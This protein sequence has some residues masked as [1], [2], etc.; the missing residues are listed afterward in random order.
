[1]KNKKQMR[2]TRVEPRAMMPLTNVEAAPAGTAQ[3]AQNLRECE[4]S[5]QVTGHPVNVGTIAAGDR[6]LTMSGGHVVTAHGQ[7]IR[8]DGST[9]ITVGSEVVGAHAVGDMIVIVTRDGLVY[10]AQQGGNWTVMNPADAVPQLAFTVN[11]STARAD[12]AAYSFAEP[13]SQWQAPLA[14]VDTTALAALL[15]TAWNHLNAD[16]RANGR[17]TAP[18]L[19]RWAV[20]LTDDTYLW[21]SDPVRVGDATL[22]NGERISALVNSS[23]NG[24]TGTQATAMTLTHYGLDIAVAQGIAPEWQAMV[25]SIDVFATSEAQLLNASQALDYRCLT[26]T[27]GQREYVLEMGLS[28]RSADAVAQQL[29]TSSWRLI[30]TADSAGGN[31]AAPVVPM[32]LTPVQCNALA[33]P[34][35]AIGVVCSTV[36]GGRLYLCTRGG[37]VVVSAPGNA[38]IE[39]HRRSVLGVEPLA[40]AVVT[41]PLY[42]GGFGRYPVY[43]F[44]DDGI[45][46]IPQS[47]TGRLG[48][49]RLVDRTVIAADVP[50][51]EAGRDVWLMS[52]HGHLCR[53]SGS[54]LAVCRR[55]AGYRGMAWCNAYHELWLLPPSGYPEVMMESGS[56]SVRTV[57]ASQLYSDP[58]HALA[59]TASGELLDL[60]NEGAAAMPVAWR[61]HPVAVDHLMA[62]PVKRVV[63]HMSG[64]D[65]SLTLR[66]T[67]QRGIMAR[68]V[69]VSRM[70]VTGAV[71]TPLASPTL[72]MHVRT[73]CLEVA[74]E[75]LTGALLMPCL[76]Y[77][78]P[79]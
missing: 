50:P 19:V 33:T 61:S 43:V 46:A 42:S 48:E 34:L 4:Q 47:A 72:A 9:V 59:V 70:T 30:A 21:M 13:Y 14:D 16:A 45:F 36:A 68:E 32:T 67:G 52:R 56:T 76:I 20:R 8:I 38:L 31:F 74:G 29:S 69:E 23:G 55:N 37:D 17:Y 54:Q 3:R 78:Q 40:I 41:K 77:T 12:I 64:D 57:A 27:T 71:N 53:L 11:T 73:L 79:V 28:R 2:K 1:M 65:V 49:A 66:V 26:R 39:A 62:Q 44:S 51:V 15:R 63:W 22:S 18:M 60:E 5:L 10:L 25:K 6:L 75:A 58:R 24:F 7:L 35:Q